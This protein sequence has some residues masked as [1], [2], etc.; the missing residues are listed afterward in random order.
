MVERE[1]PLGPAFEP[2]AFPNHAGDTGIRL[3]EATPAG[4]VEACAWPGM[5]QAL[6]NAIG[7]A[8]GLRVGAAANAAA[9]NK[10]AA[11][12]CIGPSR[13]LVRS[14]RRDL[15]ERMQAEVAPETGTVTDLSHGRTCIRV[16]GNACEWMLSKLFAV[17][18]HLTTFPA[19]T[20]L[21]T[22]HHD[23][24]AQI[25]RSGEDRFEIFVF[26]SLARAFWREL[27]EAAAETGYEVE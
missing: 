19:D 3:S 21:A 24:F 2:G 4:I 11:A 18:F 16:E 13:Y 25:H 8:T 14:A 27:R 12:L 1:S 15:F 17:D 20:G 22:A 10:D 23:I 9:S 7:K 26:R 5:E 6:R